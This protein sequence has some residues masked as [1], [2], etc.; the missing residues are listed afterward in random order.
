M[1][2]LHVRE[3]GKIVCG[4]DNAQ[5]SPDKISLKNHQAWSKLVAFVESDSLASRTFRFVKR[6]TIQVRHYVGVLSFDYLQIE[7]LPKIDDL[8]DIEQTR[9]LLWKMLSVYLNLPFIESTEAKLRI[10]DNTPLPERLITYF[11]QHLTAVVRRG[12]R[13][14]YERIEAEE[15]FL[16]GQLQVAKQ[17]RQPV[18]R[19]QLFQIE[20]DF[21]S[22][23]RAENRLIHTALITASDW[24]SE[25]ANQRLARELRFAFDNIPVSQNVANDFS[26]WRTSRDMHYYQPLLPWLKL[27][28]NQQ[29]PFALKDRQE[30]ISFLFPMEKLFE[31][32]VAHCLSKQLTESHQLK[33]QISR[34]YLAKTQ[35]QN[36]FQMKPDLAI[37]QNKKCVCILDT[38]WKII[39]TQ[40]KVF[41][42]KSDNAKQ[43]FKSRISQAD[44]YQLFA[45]GQRYLDGKGEM[46][47]IFPKTSSFLQ[48]LDPFE[49]FD[50][51]SPDSQLKL[52]AIPFCLESGCL[53]NRPEDLKAII[54]AE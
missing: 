45:Y 47:L 29:S 40:A 33:P 1:I 34:H 54:Q 16:K 39:D 22:D 36:V 12:I 52:H 24:A 49:F 26:Q 4:N 32:Y 23:N 8:Q 50:G 37:Y 35:G 44:M 17:L 7:I 30:G 13:K 27:I 25:A 53:V 46:I 14:D 2:T 3:W 31:G 48:P 51:K 38:K 20:Y 11:L 19:Q 15:R 10:K 28:L 42:D 21:F 9:N 41:N 6:D 5:I 18:G 43:D